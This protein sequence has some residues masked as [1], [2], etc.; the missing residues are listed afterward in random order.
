MGRTHFDKRCALVVSSLDELRSTLEEIKENHT[1]ANIFMRTDEKSQ[2]KDQAIFKK[3]FKQI[4]QELKAKN[5]L[6]ANDYRDNLL[7]LANFYSEGYDLGWEILHQGESKRRINLP[8]YPFAK[9]R[10]WS[11]DHVKEQQQSYEEKQIL[12]KQ[13]STESS[14]LSLEITKPTPLKLTNS[15]TQVNTLTKEK[16]YPILRDM[17]SE[18]LYLAPEK[19]ST[20]KTFAEMGFDSING[21]E[22]V[23]SINKHLQLNMNAVVLYDYPTLDVLIDYLVAQGAT[24]RGDQ[25]TIQTEIPLTESKAIEVKETAKI[26]LK[27]QD[28]VS[29]EATL[30]RTVSHEDIAIIGMAGVYPGAP[31]LKQFWSNLSAGVSSIQEIPQERWSIETYYDPDP[32]HA[33][34]GKSYCKWGGFIT[35]VE[36]FDPLFFN[37][38]PAEAEMMDPQQRITLQTAWAALEDAGYAAEKV[39]NTKCGF[40]VGV[41]NS[42]YAEVIMKSGESN[43]A[44]Q[45]VTGISNSILSARVPYFLNLK[46]PVMAVD[47]ACSS[48]LVAIH[49]ACNALQNRRSRHDV[50]RWSDIVFNRNTL[51]WHV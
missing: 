42:D 4:M 17:I 30:N 19:I 33:M 15:Q 50:C 7:A 1:A 29:K 24:V 40:Y 23:R 49:L 35:D 37:I 20:T 8:T 39:S 5:E 46:G 34:Q 16:I 36:Q 25:V 12:L 45:T 21:V 2:P 32:N 3:V 13:F 44:I 51:Y 41:M 22:L 48:S 31:S 6:D 9:D 38:S 14:K 11:E 43:T 28:T 27:I 10:Y 26:A 47:T 18:V